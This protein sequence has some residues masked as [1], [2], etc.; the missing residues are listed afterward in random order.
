V[1]ILIK[2]KK[3]KIFIAIP[4]TG[5]IRTELAITLLGL[6]R[7]QYDII[8]SFT[9]GGGIAHNRNKLVE[10]FLQTDYE[11]FLFIDSDTVPPTNIL[12]MTKNGK[13]ICSG[14]YH[15]FK[16]NKLRALVFNKFKDKFQYIKKDN[17]NALIEVDG[18]G[19]GSLLIHRNV[20]NKM[21]KPYFEFIYNE[22]GLVDL[23][24]DLNFCRKA[25]KA[26]FKIW[27]DK[28]I[29]AS[30]YKTIDLKP[31]WAMLTKKINRGA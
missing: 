16:N 3:S 18:V 17:A 21:K 22:I 11:W 31:I 5:D 30:H 1:N 10:N 12:D 27:V 23:S 9:I 25:Q 15:N 26:G 24:E 20:F 28:R 29:V 14:I 19:T 13:N 8:V 2:V 7:Q 4:T 6:N